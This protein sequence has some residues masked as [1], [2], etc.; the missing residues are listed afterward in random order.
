MEK[1]KNESDIVE[2]DKK[3]AKIEKDGILGPNWLKFWCG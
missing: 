3:F 2:C 1:K